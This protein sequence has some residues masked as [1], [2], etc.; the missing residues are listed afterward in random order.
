MG[1]QS[2]APGRESAHSVRELGAGG[3][4]AGFGPERQIA[5]SR[6]MR[7]GHPS[8]EVPVQP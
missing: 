8:V 5:D 2:P 3:P 6:A 4:A 7:A 1:W